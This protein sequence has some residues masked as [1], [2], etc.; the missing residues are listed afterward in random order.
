M[1]IKA[2]MLPSKKDQG[3]LASLGSF[4]G[5]IWERV[6]Y[7]SNIAPQNSNLNRGEWRLLE[8]YFRVLVL[9]KEE[10]YVITGTFYDESGAYSELPGADEAHVIPSGF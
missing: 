9:A 10:V 2:P 3:H 4:K 5:K 7:L 6:S 1:T 8:E